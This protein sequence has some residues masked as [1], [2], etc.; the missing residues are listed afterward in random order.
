[1]ETLRVKEDFD[2]F[3]L[4]VV[5]ISAG[6]SGR[7]GGGWATSCAQVSFFGGDEAISKTSVTG[8]VRV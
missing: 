3:P 5:V 4:P 2:V 8:K 6:S 7:V 1:M